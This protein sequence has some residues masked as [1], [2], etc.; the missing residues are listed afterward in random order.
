LDTGFGD[1]NFG[2]ITSASSPRLTQLSLE[3][4]F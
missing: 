3:L 4:S 2:S 1:V